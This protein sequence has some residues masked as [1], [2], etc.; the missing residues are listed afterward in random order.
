MANGPGSFNRPIGEKDA[1]PWSGCHTRKHNAARPRAL[2]PPNEKIRT[3]RVVKARVTSC[4]VKAL[5]PEQEVTLA[6][7]ARPAP[8]Q[9]SQRGAADART[10]EQTRQNP[11]QT[12]AGPGNP[13]RWTDPTFVRVTRRRHGA[14]WDNGRPVPGPRSS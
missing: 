14:I 10:E 4:E 8:D 9:T 13:S 3:G 11:R 5:C 6:F 1:A 7:A 12:I 2:R